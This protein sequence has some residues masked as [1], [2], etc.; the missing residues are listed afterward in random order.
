[1][2]RGL[3]ALMLLAPV[4]A[5]A[6]RG[7]RLDVRIEGVPAAVHAGESVVVS[8]G[9]LPRDVE[10]VEILLSTDDGRHFARVVSPAF[11]RGRRSH[12]WRVPDVSAGRARLM[13]RALG[14]RGER[15]GVAS[16]AFRIEPAPAAAAGPPAGPVR[17]PGAGRGGPDPG[18]ADPGGADGSDI[19]IVAGGPRCRISISTGLPEPARPDASVRAE[20]PAATPGRGPG[21]TRP[22]PVFPRRLPL[23]I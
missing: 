4:P 16:A 6:A 21:A 5:L 19:A 23:R 18:A 2:I 20:R 13:L 11:E 15:M 8:W 12:R 7:P 3:I 14:A 10:T 9:E 22:V 17:G 1:M